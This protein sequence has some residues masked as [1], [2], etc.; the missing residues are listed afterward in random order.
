[1]NLKIENFFYEKNIKV[2]DEKK[3]KLKIKNIINSF[4]NNNSFF[5]QINDCLGLS[6]EYKKL[7]KFKKFNNIIVIG[8]GGS[9]LGSSAIYSF[10][11]HKINK[12]IKFINDLEEQELNT[13]TNAKKSKNLF[14]IISKSGNTN[15]ILTIINMLGNKI[16]KKTNTIV[17]TENKNNELNNFAI[18]NGITRIPHKKN[19]GG[20]FSVLT[21]VGML[22]AFL[23][24]LNINKFKND[25]KKNTLELCK[26]NLKESTSYL[27]KIFNEGPKKNIVLLNYCKQTEDFSLWLQQLIAESLGKKNKGFLP[28]ISKCPRDHHSLLQLYLD[29]PKDKIFYIFSGKNKFNFK[30]KNNLFSKKISY[31]KNRKISDILE[32][33]KNSLLASFKDKKIPFRNFKIDEFSEETM[34]SLFMF[35]MIEV[36]LIGEMNNL[37]PFNQP[38]VEKVKVTTR[39]MLS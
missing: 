3:L 16:I 13:L 35:F 18:K 7:H 39:K 15:E 31:L 5:N 27:I 38:A 28:S 4:S 30:L 12:N 32:A 20:R 1:M 14:V 37:N 34:S 17:I 29:G 8:M 9:S 23:M 22:P 25:L 10:L 24:G 36:V 26:K 19:I 21:E 11:K 6:I 2:S 33:Q